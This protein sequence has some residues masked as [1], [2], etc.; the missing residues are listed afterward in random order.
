MTVQMT[1]TAIGLVIGILILFLVRR[2]HLH[3]PY[4]FW[5]IGAAATIVLLGLFPQLVDR[6]ALRLGIS[7]P[8]MLAMVLGLALVLLKILTMDIERSRQER[9]IRRLAQQIAMIEARKQSQADGPGE[10]QTPAQDQPAS[11]RGR[12]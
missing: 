8:P 7:Y 2:D 6:I 5:W 11:Q 10:D 1:S 9:Q 4:A 3:G 12:P